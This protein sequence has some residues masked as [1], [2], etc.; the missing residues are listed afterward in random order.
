MP[1]IYKCLISDSM[2]VRKKVCWESKESVGCDW[3]S[4]S[5]GS[6]QKNQ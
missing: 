6:I 1:S 2:D 5:W 3:E 4:E